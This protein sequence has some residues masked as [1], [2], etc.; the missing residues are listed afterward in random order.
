MAT[1]AYEGAASGGAIAS[2]IGSKS[3][4]VLI[5]I[6]SANGQRVL[7]IEAAK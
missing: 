6:M 3:G 2:A 4:S 7:I 1:V 5:P